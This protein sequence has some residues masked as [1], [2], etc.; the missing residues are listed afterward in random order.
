MP[1]PCNLS[2][3]TRE[4]VL[5]DSGLDENLDMNL[6]KFMSGIS[7]VV[8]PASASAA[9]RQTKHMFRC[10]GTQQAKENATKLKTVHRALTS[11]AREM[12]DLKENKI[13][14]V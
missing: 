10:G 8:S 11:S 5:L 9:A 4:K 7:L 12:P 14:P 13:Q 6:P 1:F 2:L 3:V